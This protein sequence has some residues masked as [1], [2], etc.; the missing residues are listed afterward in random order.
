MG[1][2]TTLMARD[3]HEFNAWLAA[4]SGPVRG[5]VVVAQEIFGVNRHIRTVADGF[6]ADG[7]LTIAPCLFDR[8]RRGIELGY[9]EADVQ[10]GRGYRLQIPKEKTLLDLSAC[11]NVVRHSG[12][13]SAIGYCW[14][15]TLAYIAACELPVFCAI[16]Y[17]GGQIKD[18]LDKSPKRPV[19][20]HFGEN[21]PH[22][23]MSDVDKIRAADPNGIF[24]L[25]PADHGFNC[26]ERAT[27]DAPSATLARQRTLQFLAAQ[28]ERK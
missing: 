15:G 20:Y 10:Q 23:P 4:P 21:D 6:A 2:F 11:I 1:E 18:H 5:A 13:V 27:Y 26:D 9:S 19:M 22:I 8:I 24:H 17:Y 12:R 14:G 28:M 3:G 7:F 16:S 25:Y